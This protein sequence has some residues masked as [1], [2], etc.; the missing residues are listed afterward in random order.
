MSNLS[1][2]IPA[3]GGQNNTDFVAD[4]TVVS[5]KGVI[6]TAV[7]KVAPITGADAAYGSVG[8]IGTDATVENA[9]YMACAYDANA[10]KTVVCYERASANTGYSAVGTVSGTSISFGTQEA[11]TGTGS[12]QN[13][14]MA[15][16]ANAQKVGVAYT[17]SSKAYI[18]AKVGTVSG[19]TISWGSESTIDSN[20]SSPFLAYD[21]NAQKVVCAFVDVGNSSYPSAYVG[22]IAGTGISWG[23]QTVYKSTA[24]TDASCAYDA[25]NQTVLCCSSHSSGSGVNIGSVS[26]SSI[27]FS[28]SWTAFT[29][30]NGYYARAAWDSNAQRI[31]ATYVKDSDSHGRAYVGSVSGTTIT[32]GSENVY[33]A[34]SSYRPHIIFNSSAGVNKIYIV[35]GNGGSSGTPTGITATVSGLTA[36]FDTA[37][38]F[39]SSG[40]RGTATG[41]PALDT[42][43]GLI[44]TVYAPDAGGSYYMPTC[45]MF[46]TG[47]TTLTATNLL[48]VASAAIA[49][50]ETGTINTWG[51]RN[52]VQTG[53][54]IGSDY[55]VQG[56]G[57]ITT[58]STS[59]AQLIG[60]A[61]SA[62][63]INIKDYTG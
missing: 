59:P 46:T 42:S 34:A 58:T 4:G 26:G 45:K 10:N 31:V 8:E 21:A 36:T 20:G 60:K 39:G 18:Y 2:L 55:Y 50:T 13:L 17:S 9:N 56:D 22:T 33:N 44:A 6:L 30:D 35:Y 7:G 15:Y 47:Y 48:G 12:P 43:S 51:S 27:S 54:T 23:A 19:T 61:I 38:V 14:S 57:T 1:D 62:T 49:D 53:L 5:G 29:T 11:F 40:S 37:V 41:K 3:G 25:T 28:G 24:A 16:D 52:E 32:W 63:Q